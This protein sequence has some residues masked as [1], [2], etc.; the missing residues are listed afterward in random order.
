MPISST[1]VIISLCISNYHVIYL[2][3]MCVCIYICI[4]TF[5]KD[6]IYLFLERGRERGR[7]RNINLWLPLTLPLLGIK[8]AT[9]WFT[10]RHSIPWATP[11]RANMYINFLKRKIKMHSELRALRKNSG[12]ELAII[13]ERDALAKI[14]MESTSEEM[15]FDLTRSR[16]T[17]VVWRSERVMSPAGSGSRAEAMVWNKYSVLNGQQ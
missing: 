11:V 5:F 10:G 13:G 12:T 6:F 8:P 16:E 4:Y 17:S 1:V 9:L 2:K 14:V 7:E 3:Y 15:I